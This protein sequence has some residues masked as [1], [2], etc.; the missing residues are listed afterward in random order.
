MI[1]LATD[2]GG[3]FTDLLGYDEAT[4]RIFTAKSLTTPDDQSEGVLDT[5][6]LATGDG[7]LR[8]DQVGFFVHGG[9]TVIN[10]IT[11]RK[12]VRTALVTTRGFRDVLEIGR[13]NRPDLYN[14]RFHS[15]RPYVERALRL[16]VA[17]RIDA[18]G[19]VHVPLNEADVA[20]AAQ[21]LR[22]E[23]VEA[24][25]ILF[26]NSY[27]NPVHEAACARLLTEALPGVTICASHEVSGLW[28]EYERANTAVL[29]AYVKPI[30][31]RYFERLETRL[32][33]NA[34]RCAHYAMLSNGGV[35]S[36]AQ[37]VESPLSLVESGP[38]GA[39]AGAARIGEFLGE[40]NVLSFDVGGTTAK[41]SVI[42]DGRPRIFDDYRME[43]SRISPGYPVQV[44]VVD[45]VEIGAGGGSIARVDDFGALTVGPDSAG[46][47]P[48]PVCYGLGGA[49][50]TVTDAKLLTGIIDP[51]SFAGGKI[52][53]RIDDARR[54]MAALGKRLGFGVEDTAQAV[55]LLAE[56][57]MI[58]AL[59]LVTIQR[60]YDPRDFTL[61]V[62]GGMGPLF[63]ARLGRELRVRRVVIP[64]HAG[65]FS[66]W[67]MLAAKPRA[68]LRKTWFS[69][70][71]PDAIP[72]L[73]AQVAAMRQDA[74]DYFGR[75]RPESVTHAL[76]LQMR[77]R[78]QE[79]S[80]TTLVPGTLDAAN[81]TQEF[82]AAHRTAYSF[83]LPDAAIE[84]TG[85]HLIAT[86]DNP[87][88]GSPSVVADGLTLEGARRG[89]RKV[90]GAAGD[91][92][93]DAGVYARDLMPPDA[94]V[95]GPALI[96]EATSTTLVLGGQAAWRDA[97]GLLIVEEAGGTAQRKGND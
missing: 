96:E 31:A 84:I 40:P 67:G 6:R 89:S 36:F 43:W 37:A 33:D 91:G 26:L 22:A 46:A 70:L 86:L 41:C 27:A 63:A 87:V 20:R 18:S 59:K 51:D 54:A 69:L 38:S 88:I 16:E 90:W 57:S 72:P 85:I 56:A 73:E 11:E 53:L 58:N 29:N 64:P 1:R 25:A 13:G 15:P 8:P 12:G 30:I 14:L 44:P 76:A 42:V 28:R 23:R 4:G 75:D 55:V 3:T 82:H 83:A 32:I 35:S 77:Y 66:A 50:P 78:G 71:S 49:E 79:H 95:P 65:I 19:A 17:E 92:W 47:N 94:A 74:L 21:V 62:T 48:G 24:V 80:V 81:I 2:V 93:A 97:H 10:A 61:M 5:L 9:T 52:T 45:I 7:G 68:D 60:G 39:V 34:V